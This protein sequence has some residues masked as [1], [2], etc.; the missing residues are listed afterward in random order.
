MNTQD[1]FL[2][3]GQAKTQLDK[4]GEAIIRIFHEATTQTIQPNTRNVWGK[5]ASLNLTFADS[6]QGAE[7]I[8]QFVADANFALTIEGITP[9]W[10]AEPTWNEGST[11]E[12]DIIDGLALC[13]E[14]KEA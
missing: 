9:R 3:L 2:T 10:A 7:Y 12:V 6:T 5:V 11:Y 8:L 4:K 13:A 14:F 1:K